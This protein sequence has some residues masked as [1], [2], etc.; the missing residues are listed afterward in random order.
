[1]LG[2]MLVGAL[3]LGGLFG[4][5]LGANAASVL[6]DQALGAAAAGLVGAGLKKLSTDRK[7]D[8][9]KPLVPV[10][11]VAAGMIY[12]AATGDNLPLEQVVAEGM[13]TGALATWAVSGR[14]NARE[15]AATRGR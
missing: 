7:Q 12:R 8:W 5:L 10:A 11:A 9:H 13:G 1:M 6:L 2:M 4:K 14:K 15:Y 3:F